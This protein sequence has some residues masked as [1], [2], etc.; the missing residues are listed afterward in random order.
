M[1]KR[2]IVAP[3]LSVLILG[4]WALAAPR[5]GNPQARARVRANIN[6]LKQ[7]QLSAQYPS[8]FTWATT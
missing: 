4:A 3:V 5:Q 8:T 2:R 7:I 1:K 6:T